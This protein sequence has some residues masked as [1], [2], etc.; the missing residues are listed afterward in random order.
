[1]KKW[2]AVLGTIL[3]VLILLGITRGSNPG[4]SSDKA[5]GPVQAH[6][7]APDNRSWATV[8]QAGISANKATDISLAVSATGTAYVAYNDTMLGVTVQRFNGTSWE[9]VGAAGF[10]PSAIPRLTIDSTGKPLVVFVDGTH[11][12]AM[13]FDGQSWVTSGQMDFSPNNAFAGSLVAAGGR[14]Y[15]AF[16]ILVG[17]DNPKVFEYNGTTWTILPPNPANLFDQLNYHWSSSLAV[18]GTG[19]PYIAT[20]DGSASGRATVT[21]WDGTS[22]VRVG[23]AGFSE[24]GETQGAAVHLPA[25]AF[26]STNHPYLAYIQDQSGPEPR[27]SVMK[28]NGAG[29]A[30]VGAAGI[31]PPA[32]ESSILVVDSLDIPFVS[33]VHTN[34]AVFPVEVLKFDGVAW[35]PTGPGGGAAVGVTT[36]AF[37]SSFVKGPSGTL[38]LAFAD[39]SAGDKVTIA[40]YR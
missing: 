20:A 18:D 33:Y 7:P 1:M 27:V 17:N 3:L 16:G 38:Y 36:D 6:V 24:G 9:L 14:L 23:S 11:A 12:Q 37:S 35:V 19:A 13:R 26:D 15:S 28:N 25:L 29:W 22:W 21:K 32:V 8:G 39:H 10:S 5:L 4:T 30:L 31:S 2:Y 40:A 34:G